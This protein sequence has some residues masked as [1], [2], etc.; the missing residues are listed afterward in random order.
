[1]AEIPVYLRSRGRPK[2]VSGAN[3]ST[4]CFDVLSSVLMAEAEGEINAEDYVLVEQWRGVERPLA[5]ASKVLR[6]WEAWGDERAHVRFVIKRVKS[7]RSGR[8]S[9]SP[10][11]ESP[12]VGVAMPDNHV[13]SAPN[14]T[15]TRQPRR[16]RRRNSVS[17]NASDTMHPRKMLMQQ[18]QQQQQQHNKSLDTS[19]NVEDMMKVCQ[20][21]RFSNICNSSTVV[22]MLN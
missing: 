17:S 13:S 2:F 6:L 3:G 5:G 11:F 20:Q 1:M 18:Q 16:L 19:Q 21:L 7:K 4:S 8:G 14:P 22:P 12:V 9:K 10:G 15:S